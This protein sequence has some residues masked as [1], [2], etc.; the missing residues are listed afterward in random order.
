MLEEGGCGKSDQLSFLC[1][2]FE[3]VLIIN[4][5][6]SVKTASQLKWIDTFFRRAP[7]KTFLLYA[8][9]F[10]FQIS[11]LTFPSFEPLTS[12]TKTT[13]MNN[14]LEVRLECAP[15]N[16]NP[17]SPKSIVFRIRLVFSRR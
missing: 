2:S 8:K 4:K 11:I 1:I 6:L 15:R 9:S 16:S 3:Q 13:L 17:H 5:D 12:L 7:M 14:L 10:L